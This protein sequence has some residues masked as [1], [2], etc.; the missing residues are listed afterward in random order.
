MM[1]F[2]REF[3]NCNYVIF[4]HL[5]KSV[6]YLFTLLFIQDPP[7]NGDIPSGKNDSVH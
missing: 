1:A 3:L 7:F 5:V 4:T 6:H 2:N